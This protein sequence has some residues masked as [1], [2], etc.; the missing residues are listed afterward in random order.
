MTIEDHIA[1]GNTVRRWVVT[2]CNQNG[3]RVLTF[4]CQ[5][6]YTY[7][8]KADAQVEIAALLEHNS[9]D[10][11]SEVYGCNCRQTLSPREVECW[12]GH[13]DPIGIYPEDDIVGWPV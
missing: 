10:R 3:I 8:T 1:A 13:H 4:A 12:K 9:S 7:A 5:G 11:L 6:R 2:H